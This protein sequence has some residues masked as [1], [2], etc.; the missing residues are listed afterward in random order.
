MVNY[1]R[2]F[3][4]QLRSVAAP[5]SELQ[6]A[7]KE[8]KWT[9]LHDVS[10]EE[11]KALIMYNKVLKPINTDPSLRTYLVCNSSDTGIAG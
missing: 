1:L 9:H 4:Q 3:C 2:Q 5:S 11:V 7:T 8:W 10:F 6:G